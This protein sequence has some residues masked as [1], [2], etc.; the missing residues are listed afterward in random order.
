MAGG[1]AAGS[2]HRAPG[3]C[4]GR[5][6]LVAAAPARALP[7]RPVEHRP[8]GAGHGA[9]TA[10]AARRAPARRHGPGLPAAQMG[11][12]RRGARGDCPLGRQG[13]ERLDQGALGPRRPA[14]ARGRAA[15]VDRCPGLRQGPGRMGLL[16]A[17]GHGG[18][19]AGLAPAELQKLARSAP[20]H[21]GAVSRAGA[22]FGGAHAAF[23]LGAAHGLAHGCDAG[24]GQPGGAVVAGRLGGRAPQPCSAHPHRAAARR[25]PRCAA[26]SGLRH[27]GRMAGPPRRAVRLRALRGQ[28]RRPPL[29]HR[30]RR[31]Q[32]GPGR[33]RRGAP[34]AGDQ[35]ARRLHPHAAP[36]PLRRPARGHR[37][38]LR[39][40]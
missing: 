13:I 8:D 29:H 16:P 37:R 12:H 3:R 5:H 21:A 22:A 24:P 26:G 6:G 30:Q 14:G 9:G 25:R 38:P 34:A 19:D 15:L 20:G 4:P 1:R 40:V 31:G 18:A 17:P 36:T 28:R 7:E 33:A 27:A 23:L 10:P 32:P 35:A 39:S 2:G 11:G